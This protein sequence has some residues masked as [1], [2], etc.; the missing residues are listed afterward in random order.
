MLDYRPVG[1]FQSCRT[2]LAACPASPG[3]TQHRRA[4]GTLCWLGCLVPVW[5]VVRLAF[6]PRTQGPLTVACR[7]RR[8]CLAP[9][10]CRFV[11]SHSGGHGPRG[12]HQILNCMRALT[13]LLIQFFLLVLGFCFGLCPEGF[14]EA[15][16]GRGKAHIPTDISRWPPGPPRAR[17]IPLSTPYLLQ[18]PTE[19]PSSVQLGFIEFRVAQCRFLLHR[20]PLSVVSLHG[21]THLRRSNP[22]PTPSL[23]RPAYSPSKPRNPNPSP[24]V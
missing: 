11:C 15:P 20:F 24:S 16:E 22:K 1:R 21:P 18:G 6:R 9:L 7:T 14:R 17:V 8:S 13:P 4:S 2:P 23:T 10:W 3:T 12:P 5:A 19:R